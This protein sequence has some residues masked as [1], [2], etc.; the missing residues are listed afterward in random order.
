[1]DE[2]DEGA[3]AVVL[4]AG[5]AGRE[6][7]RC[8]LGGWAHVGER[9]VV[10]AQGGA[11]AVLRVC[12]THVLS[13]REEAEAIGHHCFR[14]RVTPETHVRVVGPSGHSGVRCGRPH[15]CPPKVVSH[16]AGAARRSKQDGSIGATHSSASQPPEP[17][18]PLVERRPERGRRRDCRDDRRAGRPGRSV[19][20]TAAPAAAVHPAHSG[21]SGRAGAQG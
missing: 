4:E 12:G 5:E 9:V 13:A 11:L 21:A 8:K 3:P 16:V 17:R 14:G 19:R 7:L 1:M 10:R 2:D 20:G 15:A 6:V 18:P